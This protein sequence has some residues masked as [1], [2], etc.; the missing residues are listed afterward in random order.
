M[1]LILTSC[2]DLYSKNKAG[3]RIAHNFGNVNGI[4][5]L[6]KK[7]T[8]KQENF[9]FVAST[10]FNYEATDIYA[11]VT[12]ESFQK[13]FPFI[14]YTILDGRTK[15]NARKIIENADFIFLCGGHVPTQNKFFKNINLREIIKNTNAL[16]VG[17]SAGSMNCADVVYA[18]PELEGE[19]T[20]PNYKKYIQG[21]GLTNIS[22]LPHFEQRSNW[23]LDGKDL[24][25]DISIPDS[26][27]RPFIAYSDGAYI[28]D[29]EKTQIMYGKAYLFDNGSFQQISQ[30]NCV[31][32]ITELV[33]DKFNHNNNILFNE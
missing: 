19:S 24:L 3:E 9:V 27:I 15:N 23:S 8:P 1:N 4:L 32:D 13:T 11:K 12:F 25:K 17:G 28:Y 22:I 31:T 2:L 26:K 16:I 6:I 33:D 30:D 29:N 18:Q 10:E 7:L 5:D 21:L 20:D 14:N